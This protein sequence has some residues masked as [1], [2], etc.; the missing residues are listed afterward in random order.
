MKRISC[1][2]LL[3]VFLASC[4]NTVTPAP[5]V[6]VTFKVTVT[7]ALK[8]LFQQKHPDRQIRRIQ[9]HRQDENKVEHRWTVV[10]ENGETIYRGWTVNGIE[11]P[12]SNGE[13][14]LI[15]NLAIGLSPLLWISAFN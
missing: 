13:V 7:S 6:T 11:N 5:N 1:F 9:T 10:E 8:L 2:L 14:N 15:N 12:D 3:S 4:A